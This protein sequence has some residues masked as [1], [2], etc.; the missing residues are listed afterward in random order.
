MNDGLDRHPSRKRGIK[1]LSL[2]QSEPVTDFR[3]FDAFPSFTV[4]EARLHRLA[5]VDF[6]HQIIPSDVLWSRS[7]KRL[8]SSLMFVLILLLVG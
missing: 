3:Y 1:V 8:A 4:I 6:V 5:H 2:F 7:S